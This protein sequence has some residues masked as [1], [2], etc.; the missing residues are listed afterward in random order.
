MSNNCVNYQTGELVTNQWSR[1][2]DDDCAIKSH[3]R[4][5]EG[6]NNYMMSNFKQCNDCGAKTAREIALKQPEMQVSDGVGWVSAG[7]CKVD[8]D[9]R[10]RN[11]CKLTN[12]K[13]INQLFTRPYL[14]VPYMG[15]GC[16]R[17]D[18]ESDLLFS[19]QTGEKRSC[20]VLSGVS[21]G[22]FFTPMIPD[23]EKEIQNPENLIDETNGWIRGGESTRQNLKEI[24]YKRVC[25]PHIM[26]RQTLA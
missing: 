23:L 20:N 13:I 7:G 15:N 17:P 14:T 26:Q 1:L 10:V 11:G 16:F 2:K 19:E 8:D 12:P 22:N 18:K 4:E 24:D 5:S 9:S 6:I 21:I 25:L 3:N